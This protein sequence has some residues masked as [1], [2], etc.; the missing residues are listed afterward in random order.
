LFP[1]KQDSNIQ[2][3]AET[4]ITGA[5]FASR[6][7]L[8]W[9]QQSALTLILLLCSSSNSASAAH[10]AQKIKVWTVNQRCQASGSFVVKICPTAVRIDVPNQHF[11]LVSRA[12]KWQVTVF[13]EERKNYCSW[14]LVNYGG[15][16]KDALFGS[17]IQDREWKK[18]ATSKSKSTGL[19]MDT[20]KEVLKPGVDYSDAE[21]QAIVCT[22]PQ[23][24]CS[25]QGLYVYAR[26]IKT[27]LLNVFP[28]EGKIAKSL[29]GLNAGAPYLSTSSAKEEYVS[30]TLFDVPAGLKQVKSD[31]LVTGGNDDGFSELI[32]TK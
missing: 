2:K 20:M 15:L 27:P 12:Q 18:I 4:A 6:A 14:P 26:T 32:P 5:L 29:F 23:I 7:K 21:K 13:S 25:Q 19:A 16:R 1:E 9:L 28:L 10:A 11:T 22:A 8:Q 17:W 31:P 30:N 24:R 3:N